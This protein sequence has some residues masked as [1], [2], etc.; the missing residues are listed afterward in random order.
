MVVFKDFLNAITC[1]KISFKISSIR[2]K[3]RLNLMLISNPLIKI[4][5]K[6]WLKIVK[7]C[8]SLT[9]CFF[10]KVPAP[11]CKWEKKHSLFLRSESYMNF[12]RCWR[13]EPGESLLCDWYYGLWSTKS[14]LNQGVQHV[15]LSR[16][17]PC[18]SC[19][20]WPEICYVQKFCLQKHE[21][22]SLL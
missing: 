1:L 20:V 11:A 18:L 17:V 7:D 19:S 3:K 8:L 13:R 21:T 4:D 22:I 6:N 10:L 15:F 14:V 2:I 12:S 16:L 5:V 9:K